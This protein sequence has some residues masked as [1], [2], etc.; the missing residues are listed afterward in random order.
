[1]IVNDEM[2][3][4]LDAVIGGK[5]YTPHA[6]LYIGLLLDLPTNAGSGFTE[7]TGTAYARVTKTNNDT[8]FPDCTP[9]SREKSNGTVITF[10]EAGGA[11]GT[12][13][14]VGIFDAVS[15]GN[16]IAIAKEANPTAITTGNIRSY[17]VGQLKFIA[18]GVEVYS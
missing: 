2:E 15:G 5:T 6:T 3:A 11:W 18:A 12:P 9:G 17:A 16:L 10:P 4:V 8:N 1:M 14:Y 13:E 7:V